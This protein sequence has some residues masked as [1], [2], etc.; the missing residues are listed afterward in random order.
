MYN[1]GMS[2]QAQESESTPQKAIAV[3]RRLEQEYGR[4]DWHVAR[5]PLDELVMTILSQHTSDVNCERAFDSLKARFPCWADVANADEHEIEDAIR[6]GGLAATKAPRIKHVVGTVLAENS[7]DNLD[8]LPLAE[9]K[10]RLQS[11]PG[12]GPKT[13]ACVLLFACKRPALPVDTHVHRV[14]RRIGLIENVTDAERAHEILESM[15]PAEDVYSFHMNVITHGRR[16]CGA[17]MPKCGTCVLRDL[18]S[19]AAE[20]NDNQIDPHEDTNE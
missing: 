13:A 3:L 6:P 1:A 2:E 8:H 4:P 9:A 17:R 10:S 19:F 20:N 7:L 11:L 12:V 18:C 15:L 16:V 5:P 14:S